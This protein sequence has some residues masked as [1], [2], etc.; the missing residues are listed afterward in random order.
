MTELSGSLHGYIEAR[1][2]IAVPEALVHDEVQMDP[3]GLPPC[4]G[5]CRLR[6][7]QMGETSVIGA[8]FPLSNSNKNVRGCWGGAYLTLANEEG[9]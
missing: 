9:I 2:G 3:G 4:G 1:Y 6:P 8:S 5:G 7:G